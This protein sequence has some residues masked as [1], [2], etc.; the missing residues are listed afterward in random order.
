MQSA[1]FETYYNERDEFING[2]IDLAGLQ[3]G[4]SG[5]ATSISATVITTTFKQAIF[6]KAALPRVSSPKPK[7]SGEPDSRQPIP[8][9]VSEMEQELVEL[10][11][12]AEEQN[13]DARAV[14]LDV[15]EKRPGKGSLMPTNHVTTD[16]E[17]G[18]FK[19]KGASGNGFYLRAGYSRTFANDKLTIGGTLIA[20]TMIMM[21]KLFFNNA[22]NCYG[23]FLVSQ[24]AG[25][26][27]K[28][29][30]SFNAFIVDGDFAGAPLGMSA[31]LNYSDN[32]FLFTDHIFTYGLMVQ[33]SILADIK[34]TLVT[35]GMLYGLP[36]FRRYALNADVIYAYNALTM[37][38]DGIITPDNPMMLQPGLSF[39]IFF[40]RAFSLDLGGKTTLL[41]SDYSDV[42]LT[43]GT[44]ILF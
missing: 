4:G 25:L 16:L 11:Q 6:T 32:W 12:N 18:M 33:E 36:L 10:G 28:I 34:T 21:D 43:L 14:D 37:D 8:G 9:R 20:N 26:E 40:S 41:I 5:G 22:L 23:T 24:S 27:R 17:W 2:V 7:P 3:C 44:V 29:G 15:T 19:N 39:T 13:E 31:V 42:I 30:G 38:K 35:A 1:D